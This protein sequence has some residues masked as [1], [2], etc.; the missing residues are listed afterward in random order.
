MEL[1][2]IEVLPFQPSQFTST[3]P[4]GHVE[5][6]YG[7]FSNPKGCKE[8]LH[9]LDVENVRC[10]FTFCRDAHTRAFGRASDWIPVSELPPYGMVED[11]A[12]CVANLLFG[13]ACKRFGFTKFARY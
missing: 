13:A 5:K 7:P 1:L 8:Q 11:T 3:Q 12:H 9:F 6:H 10:A 2:E 4:G